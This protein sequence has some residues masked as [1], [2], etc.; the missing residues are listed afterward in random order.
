MKPVRSSRLLPHE[1][2]L[3]ERLY[4]A[5]SESKLPRRGPES[6][7]LYVA[8]SADTLV[9]WVIAVPGLIVGLIGVITK[10]SDVLYGS[11]IV[12]FIAACVLV[13]AAVRV[14]QS[15]SAYHRYRRSRDSEHIA[16]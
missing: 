16:R 4:K 3:A 2:Y 15:G 1:R 14:I 5:Q 7:R 8:S 12:C 9:G 6:T 13:L 10:A 11:A